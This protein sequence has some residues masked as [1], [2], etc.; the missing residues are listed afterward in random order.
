M[1]GPHPTTAAGTCECAVLHQLLRGT[2]WS[3][4][5]W[6][7]GGEERREVADHLQPCVL[8][9]WLADR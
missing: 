3:L 8:Q 5:P 9:G 4:S 2:V 6:E 7:G 1:A